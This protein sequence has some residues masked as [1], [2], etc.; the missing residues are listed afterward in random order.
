MTEQLLQHGAVAYYYEHICHH[1]LALGEATTHADES[2]LEALFDIGDCVL[3][4]CIGRWIGRPEL[5]TGTPMPDARLVQA[6]VY[7]RCQSAVVG[8]HLVGRHVGCLP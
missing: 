6:H 5:V 2:L 8:G 3:R 1:D 4:A 7:T